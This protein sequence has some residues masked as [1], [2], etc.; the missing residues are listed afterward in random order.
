MGMFPEVDVAEKNSVDALDLSLVR[1]T[2]V[3]DEG[4][5]EEE[6]LE[7]ELYYK[8]FLKLR[9]KFPDDPI[10]PTKSID[11][12]WH[13]HILHTRKYMEDCDAVFGHYLH[14]EPNTQKGNAAV[15]AEMK[16]CFK[17]TRARYIEA[18]GSDIFMPGEND[19]VSA[20]CGNENCGA[21]CQGTPAGCWDIEKEPPTPGG[22]VSREAIT[23]G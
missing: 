19:I 9:Q 13:H 1:M 22:R 15:E 5:T 18:Y 8:N 12:M 11:K 3:R 10:V 2:L 23:E 17:V 16:K 20:D 21:G 4:V 6:A 7:I 14:H